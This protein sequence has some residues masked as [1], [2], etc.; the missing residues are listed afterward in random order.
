MSMS[1]LH[2]GQSACIA[3]LITLLTASSVAAKGN[4][5]E[6][7]LSAGASWQTS[8]NVQIPNDSEGTRFAL[9]DIAG[10]GPF[11]AARVEAIWNYSKKHAVRVLLAP[12]S[13]SESGSITEPIDF[14]G[15]TFTTGQPVVGEYT[16][17]SWRVG[18]RYHWLQR[19]SWDLWIGATLKV[20]D[21]EIRL[22]QGGNSSTDDDL[23]FVPLL[24]LAGEY[25]VSSRWFLAAD[26]DA[27]AGGPGRAIDPGLSVNY[28]A[29]NNLSLGIEYRTLEGGADI[30]EVYNF[31]WFNSALLT[32]HYT[33]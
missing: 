4:S 5:L 31:A 15:S 18:Y 28:K 8:N 17:N 19:D 7:K 13:Y 23:G 1:N 9:D 21:A 14:A 26:V 12:L 27:L 24:H 32:A 2:A 29:S 30:D 3:L 11:P 16:F 10:K 25:R 33:L 22:A 6:L 20:R